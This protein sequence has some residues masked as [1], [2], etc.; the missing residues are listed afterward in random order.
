MK[1]KIVILGIFIAGL[2]WF[3]ESTLHSLVY[4]PSYNFIQHIF[5]MDP[6]E[7]WMRSFIVFITLISFICI[8]FLVNRI[9][10]EREKMKSVYIKAELYKNLFAHDIRN[11]I[12][13]VKLVSEILLLVSKNTPKNQK[14]INSVVALKEQVTKSNLLVENFVGLDHLEQED[15]ILKDV[16][17]IKV[18]NTSI[19][20]IQKGLYGKVININLNTS[21]ENIL[22]RAD[23]F[24]SNVFDNILYNA[25][26][27]NDHQIIEIV[28]D[29]TEELKNGGSMLKIEIKDNGYGIP[30]KQRESLF[31]LDYNQIHK[32]TGLGLGLYLIKRIINS[33]NGSIYVENVKKGDYSKGS[34]FVIHI[35]I[36]H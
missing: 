5:W 9:N 28:I 25:I 6:N 15:I 22:V 7:L 8:Q 33:Y 13:N 32:T 26:K 10:T 34:N 35:P 12:N 36:Q 23:K 4:N 16:D 27:Y 2:Y 1:N 30:D 21:R 24:L 14:I 31:Q 20:H 3:F 29:I 17:M 18:L 19:S 11:I